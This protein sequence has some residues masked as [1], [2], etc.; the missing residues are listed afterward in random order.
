MAI[1]YTY[2]S[3]R[4]AIQGYAED[5]DIDFTN[6]LDDMIGKAETRVLRDLDLELFE[7]WLLVT[8]SGSNRNVVKPADT[9]VINDLWIRNP[10]DQKWTELPRRSFEYCLSYAPTESVTG[11]PKFYSEFD[12]DDIYVV[13]TPDQSY[14]GGNA[15]ARCTIRPTMLSGSNENS[16]LGDNLGDMLFDA[17]MIEA[18]V[19]L[20]NGPKMTEAATKYQSL[21]PGIEREMEQATRKVYKELN[22]KDLKEGADD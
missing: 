17:C 4:A 15:R 10:S 5:T 1:Q 22:A 19:F 18:Y 6:K 14:S 11:V 16:W 9:I 20:K 3:L 21:L 13:P 8:V 12:A 2:T 7:Q